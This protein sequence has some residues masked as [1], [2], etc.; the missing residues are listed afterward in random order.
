MC[1]NTWSV[2]PKVC[3][4]S[5]S[6]YLYTSTTSSGS[7]ANLLPLTDTSLFLPCNTR[8]FGCYKIQNFTLYHALIT[9]PS[10][11]YSLYNIVTDGDLKW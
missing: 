9:K 6:R 4:I 2:L 11:T 5:G 8:S 3:R 1:G 10:H 7:L